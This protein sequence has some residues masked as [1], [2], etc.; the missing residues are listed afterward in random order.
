MSGRGLR[1]LLADRGH[2][3][4]QAVKPE[5]HFLDMPPRWLSPRT[6]RDWLSDALGVCA[7]D[8]GLAAPSAS[9]LLPGRQTRS[10]TCVK[11]IGRR[12]SQPP[13]RPP[14]GSQPPSSSWGPRLL[15]LLPEGPAALCLR[16]CPL[17]PRV[18]PL[19]SSLRP[20]TPLP[21]PRGTLPGTESAA[22]GGAGGSPAPRGLSRSSSS[23]LGSAGSP[24]DTG[25]P[26][27]PHGT[28]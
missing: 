19:P 25:L 6:K 18:S 17:C 27:R 8:P 3:L 4:A 26:P 1:C 24:R 20:Q 5:G 16:A 10:L 15:S 22:P 2:L 7:P 23:P 12:G 11:V 14:Q 28:R 13:E 9:S 21:T